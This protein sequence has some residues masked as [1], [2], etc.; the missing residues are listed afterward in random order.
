M[1]GR[2]QEWILRALCN[3]SRTL[4]HFTSL[5]SS[6]TVV[7]TR[8]CAHRPFGHGVLAA[9]AG[10]CIAVVVLNCTRAGRIATY[11]FPGALLYTAT[12]LSIACSP[13]PPWMHPARLGACRL[14][15]EGGTR[16]YICSIAS[17]TAEQGMPYWLASAPAVAFPT[18]IC[19]RIPIAPCAPHAIDTAFGGSFAHFGLECGTCKPAISIQ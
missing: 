13:W 7:C 1:H 16:L 9:N 6:T 12:A 2:A 14:V 10:V 17:G 3:L 15:T 18:R 8:S 5:D 11:N 4:L 19:A